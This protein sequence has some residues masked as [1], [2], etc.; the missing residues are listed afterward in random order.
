MFLVSTVNPVGI[1]CKF[2]SKIVT[3]ERGRSLELRVPI[4]GFESGEPERDKEVLKILKAEV[5]PELV[6]R[7]EDLGAE[8]ADKLFGKEKSELSA[9]LTIGGKKFTI[10]K[11]SYQ[12]EVREGVKFLVGHV[13]TTFSAFDIEPPAVAGGLVAKVQDVLELHYQI[14]K[15]RIQ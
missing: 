15:D 12:I 14:R 3:G 13:S 1:N 10:P 11:V 9:E 7:T 2:N 4:E 8:G 5:Q 6:I